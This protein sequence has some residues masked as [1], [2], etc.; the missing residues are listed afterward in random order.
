MGLHGEQGASTAALQPVDAV[1]SQ[2]SLI[3]SRA[4]VHVMA[5]APRSAVCSKQ[6]L[7]TCPEG[8]VALGQ[9]REPCRWAGCC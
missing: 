5:S 6:L 4:L 9:Q 8:W 3:L 7:P 1:V 2:V